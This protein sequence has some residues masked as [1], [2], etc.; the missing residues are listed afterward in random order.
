[1]QKWFLFII[2]QECV[3]DLFFRFLFYF[4][5]WHNF[6]E[7]CNFLQ[8]QTIL[9][10]LRLKL[11]WSHNAYKLYKN[12]HL[13]GV[14][15]L[16]SSR[17]WLWQVMHNSNTSNKT[18]K[19]TNLWNITSYFKELIIVCTENCQIITF[20]HSSASKAD[21]T[22]LNIFHWKKTWLCTLCPEFSIPLIYFY[23]ISFIHI[24]IYSLY[25]PLYGITIFTFSNI[26]HGPFRENAWV[27]SWILCNIHRNL[28]LYI[29]LSKRK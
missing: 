16:F 29:F 7:Q 4:I 24:F 19:I 23:K 20:W 22:I 18:S 27:L 17:K 26:E 13:L 6:P 21:Y 25:Y 3:F 11:I 14:F 12:W 1:M 10:F 8:I 15:L 28:T 5:A 9:L 2:T